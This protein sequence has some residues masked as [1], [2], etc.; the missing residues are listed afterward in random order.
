MASTTTSVNL[1]GVTGNVYAAAGYTTIYSNVPQAN[2]INFVVGSTA[3]VNIINPSYSTDTAT[4]LHVLETIQVQGVSSSFTVWSYYGL[5]TLTGYGSNAG[6]IITFQLT[7]PSGGANNSGVNVQFLDGTLAFTSNISPTGV[8]TTWVTQGGSSTSTWGTGSYALPWTAATARGLNDFAT[9]TLN[10]A[11]NSSSVSNWT[12]ATSYALTTGTDTFTLVGSSTVN[13]TFNGTGQ[14]LTVGD[15]VAGGTTTSNVINLSDLGTGAVTAPTALGG[16][17]INGVQTAN[18]TSGEALTVNTST[19]G[20]Q[21]WSGLTTLTVTTAG[22]GSGANIDTVTAAATTAVTVSDTVVAGGGAVNIVTVNGGSVVVINEANNNLNISG[23]TIQALGGTG[24]TSV[25]VKQTVNTT[26]GNAAAVTITDTNQAAGTSAGVITTVSLQGTGTAAVAINDSSLANL[27]IANALAGGTTTIT[28][29]TFATPA[30]TLALTLNSDASTTIADAGNKYT[31][32]NITTGTGTVTNSTTYSTLAAFTDTALRTVTLAGTGELNWTTFNNA[33]TSLTISGTGGL[34]SDVSGAAAGLT[35]ITATNT[36]SN[37]NNLTLSATAQNYSHTG[38]SRDIITIG[39]RETKVVTAGSATNNEIIYNAAGPGAGVA[40]TNGGTLSN[41]TILGTAASSQGT[42]D[43]SQISGITAIDVTTDLAGATVFSNVTAGTSLALDVAGTRAI[44]YTLANTLGASNS[45]NLTVGVA[46]T[47]ARVTSGIFTAT[48]AGIAGT[49]NTLTLQDSTSGTAIGPGTLAVTSYAST[50]GAQNSVTTLADTK[51]SSLTVT[52]TAGFVVGTLTG[53]TATSMTINSTSTGTGASGFGTLTDTALATL[54]FSGTGL[55]S[56]ATALNT[57]V[58]SL[59]INQNNTNS[60]AVAINAFTDASLSTLNVA[61]TNALSFTGGEATSSTLLTIGNTNSSTAGVTF[62]NLTDNTLATLNL[63]GTG[64]TSFTTLTD[65]GTGLSILDSNTGVTTISTL[66]GAALTSLTVQN[67]STGTITIGAHTA[68]ALATLNLL[69]NVTYTNSADAVTGAISVSGST[70]NA[71]VTLAFSG[72][73]A[74][75]TAQ[76]VSLGN[77]NNSITWATAGAA[78][79]SVRNVTVGNGNNT[80]TDSATTANAVDN[81]TVGSGT[82]AI[83]FNSGGTHTVI[84]TLTFSAA[85]GA[86]QTSLTTVT[87]SVAG[88]T[89][90]FANAALNTSATHLGA[91]S[92]VAAGV[93]AV[94]ASNGYT[95][96]TFG[97][98]S[99]IYENTGTAANNELVAIVGAHV[100]GG[101]TATSTTV[102]TLA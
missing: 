61:G 64:K 26:A 70:D 102:Y 51:L 48:T 43:L 13:G 96:F 85:N 60:T 71:A 20:T 101:A 23:D 89:I 92:S 87:N 28:E 49:S 72:T 7:T 37:I 5:I 94:S 16:V 58:T 67:S 17:Q 83:S 9:T 76:T 22:A 99:Y 38:S 21:G 11:V 93:A 75:G 47:D 91:V 84:D 50:A 35:T 100:I 25:T 97:G 66:S 4:G 82:N 29:G 34:S 14:T 69:N 2:A 65:G 30:T 42:F 74:S 56:I 15:T 19:T 40:L 98:S 55:E 8:W 86:S 57:S 77:G 33:V 24:T 81:F 45:V 62:N 73:E 88:D 44:T 12:G 52:G 95:D 63:S 53:D 31:T 90:T 1:T 80:I 68:T 41:F 46:T 18:F 6:Q 78:T 27:T 3:S 39:A 10:T 36:G 79:T 59:T 54:T 32:L